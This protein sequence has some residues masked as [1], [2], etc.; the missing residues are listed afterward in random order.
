M[1]ALR[2]SAAGGD[3]WAPRGHLLTWLRCLLLQGLHRVPGPLCLDQRPHP[4]LGRV[5]RG[6]AG[7]YRRHKYGK[8]GEQPGNRLQGGHRPS[9]IFPFPCPVFSAFFFPHFPFS[10]VQAPSPHVSSLAWPA[11][12]PAWLRESPHCFPQKGHGVDSHQCPMRLAIPGG[13]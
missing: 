10:R 1:G 13:Q 2:P 12:L 6:A 8:L 3:L 11:A 9:S 4:G 7:L 5:G